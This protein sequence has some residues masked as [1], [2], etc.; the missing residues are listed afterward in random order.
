MGEDREK[1]FQRLLG[2][3]A[4]LIGS[5]GLSV[6]ELG[7]HDSASRRQVQ[8]DLA[9]LRECGLALH[10]TEGEESVPRYKLENLRLA[11][12]QLDFEETLAVTLATLLA[13]PSEVGKLARQ[14][15]NKLHYAV[16]NGQ[17]RK[18]RNDLP[19]RVS[20]RAAWQLPAALMKVISTALLESR[21]LR[22][23]YQG[24]NDPE[25]RWRTV[26][27]WQLF[28][29]DRWYLRAWD[30]TSQGCRNFR[31]ERMQEC[32]LTN[33]TFELPASQR[34]T[35]PHFHK[36]DLVVAE[37]VHVVC[38]VDAKIARWLAENPVH[39]TQTLEGEVFA[40]QVRDTESFLHWALGLS[41]CE[42]IEP[43]DLRQRMKSRLQEM[44]ARMDSDRI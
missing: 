41:H 16:A 32:E 12:S 29:Q 20:A 35:D 1:Q 8:R 11:G 18:A 9:K 23:L 39:P 26:E 43:L 17:E 13:G 33:E 5:A 15:W 24:F 27:P 7:G 31:A 10:S 42:V 21:R 6:R 2:L 14:G 44:L 4:R 28:F 36:W 30:P 38:R 40:L 19:A 3:T 37:P 22:L 34:G 25:P